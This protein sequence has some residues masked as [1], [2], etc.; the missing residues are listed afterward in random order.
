[1]SSSASSGTDQGTE[2]FIA[3]GNPLCRDDGV[4]ARVLELLQPAASLTMIQ[5]TPELAA[6]IAGARRVVFI[7]A[8]ADS[9]HVRLDP[10]PDHS[11]TALTH[12][13]DP[14]TIVALSRRLYGFAGEAWLCRVPGIDFTVGE[15]LS[16]TGEVNAELAVEL[17]RRP[18]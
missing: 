6:E 9:E 2:L 5:A 18:Q 1:M 15:G 8:C 4:A 11:S 16:E 7:D 14:G 12:S 13:I 17:L 10:L 3:L